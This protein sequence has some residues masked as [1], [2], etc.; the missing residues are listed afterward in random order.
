MRGKHI[1]HKTKSLPE[2]RGQTGLAFSFDEHS[3]YITCDLFSD[4]FS[5]F[6]SGTVTSTYGLCRGEDGM[7]LLFLI[8][9]AA[10]VKTM[11]EP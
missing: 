3:F 8:T 4:T 5:A 10:K 1:L 7:V 9:D 11:G 2:P 6:A